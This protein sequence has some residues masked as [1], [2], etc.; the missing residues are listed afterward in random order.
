MVTIQSIMVIPVNK[1]EI[2]L[3]N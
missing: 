1:L 3:I 2:Y